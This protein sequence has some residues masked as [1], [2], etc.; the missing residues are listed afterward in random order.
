MRTMR[1]AGPKSTSTSALRTSSR[2]AG[3][4]DR[5]LADALEHLESLGAVFA[6]VTER[7]VP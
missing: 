7:L 5:D 4:Y 1:S 6:A 3:F 2:A